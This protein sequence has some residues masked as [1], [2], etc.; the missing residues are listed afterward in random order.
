MGRNIGVLGFERLKVTFKLCVG[1][2]FPILE[3]KKNV[4]YPGKTIFPEPGKDQSSRKLCNE[5]SA[6]WDNGDQT[7]VS[8]TRSLRYQFSARLMLCAH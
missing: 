4:V 8:E 6:F 5:E 7:K 2:F 1:L 3:R